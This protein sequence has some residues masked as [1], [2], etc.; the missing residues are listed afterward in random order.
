M[1]QKLSAIQK[2]MKMHEKFGVEIKKITEEDLE[3]FTRKGFRKFLALEVENPLNKIKVYK[4][5]Q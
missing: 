1:R 4:L 3:K 5:L 2:N